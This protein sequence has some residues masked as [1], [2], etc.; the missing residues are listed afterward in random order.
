[1]TTAHQ[2]MIPSQAAFP[3]ARAS[4]RL[5][6]DLPEPGE[7]RRLR[8]QWG[9]STRQ[10]AMAF[11]VTPA[12][13]RSWEQGRTT[14]RGRRKEAYQRFLAGLAQHGDTTRPDDAV[15]GAD[16]DRRRT[17]DVLHPAPRPVDTQAPAP[18]AGGVVRI[19]MG[20]Q[21]G[22]DPVTPEGIRR[23]RLLGAAACVWSLALWV[24][25]TCPPPF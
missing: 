6:C 9:L 11:G 18:V 19:A 20:G 21:G 2:Q 1:M 8:E 10:V 3:P 14:P 16:R 15:P 12:T 22:Q 24:M 25:L 23:L 5:R 13:V 4:R 7:R 17:A